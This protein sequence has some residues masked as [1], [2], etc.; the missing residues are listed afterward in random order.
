MK[1]NQWYTDTVV[2]GN[3]LGRKYGFPTINLSNPNLFSENDEGVYAC[4]VQFNNQTYQG[5]LFFGPRVVLGETNQILE[6]NLLNFSED[7]YGKRISFRPIRFIRPVKMFGSMEELADQ[8]RKDTIAATAVF[9]EFNAQ[10]ISTGGN[11]IK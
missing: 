9:K 7:V 4:L 8:I 1:P 3:A 5:L 11:L 2:S 6:I 10:P